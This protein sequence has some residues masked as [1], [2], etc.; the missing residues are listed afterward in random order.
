MMLLSPSPPFA[1]A[2]VAA[3]IRAAMAVGLPAH[4]AAVAL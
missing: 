1:A 4:P 2:A 3:A